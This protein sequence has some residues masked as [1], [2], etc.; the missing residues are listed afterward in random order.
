MA[1]AAL[2]KASA[3]VRPRATMPTS[4]VWSNVSNGDAGRRV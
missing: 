3:S 4:A 2:A 1:L